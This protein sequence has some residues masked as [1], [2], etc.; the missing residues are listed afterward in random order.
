[1]EWFIYVIKS[2]YINFQTRASR[3]EFWTFILYSILFRMFFI[4]IDIVLEL[5]MGVRPLEIMSTEQLGALTIGYFALLYDLAILLP[6]LGIMARRLHDTSKSG[7]LLVT[8]LIPFLGFIGLIY[9]LIC[10]FSKGDE[11]ENQYGEDP[12]KVQDIGYEE[13]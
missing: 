1:M 5:Y 6:L 13:L 2:Q 10:W 8:P 12:I 7:W 3:Q 4:G 11:G 9:I